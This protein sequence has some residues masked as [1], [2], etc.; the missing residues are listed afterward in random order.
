MNLHKLIHNNVQQFIYGISGRVALSHWLM[1][2]NL[3]IAY[4]TFNQKKIPKII[5]IKREKEITIR[6][7]NCSMNSHYEWLEKTMN[8]YFTTPT[9][10]ICY[11]PFQLSFFVNPEAQLLLTTTKRI[12]TLTPMCIEAD[13]TVSWAS[14][15]SEVPM[16]SY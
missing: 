7:S 14:L 12:S 3:Q 16:K 8:S 9:N 6:N 15:Q 11:F 1:G 10:S 5:L 4:I 2:W 13:W